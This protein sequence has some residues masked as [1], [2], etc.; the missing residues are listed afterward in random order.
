[1]EKLFLRAV[2]GLCIVCFAALSAAAV[3][4]QVVESPKPVGPKP[5]AP[6]PS[7]TPKPASKVVL[8][9]T[10]AE[11]IAEMVVFY[12]AFPGGR[13]TLNQIRKTTQEHGRSTVTDAS[14]RVDQAVYQR[15]VIRG[16][17]LFKE[18]IRLDQE[19]PTAKF[20]LVYNDENIFGIYNNSRF[21]P[22][23][24]ALKRFENQIFHGLEALLSYK[25][26]ESKLELQPREKLMGV[27]YYVVDVTDKQQRMTRF[28]ISAK[29]YRVMML[30]YEDEGV[31]YK[32]KFYDY[33]YAQGTLVPYRSVLWADDK[34]VEESEVLTVTFGQKVDE[35]MFKAGQG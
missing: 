19:L 20:A 26:N 22:R 25:E 2:I 33:N 21:T 3:F 35:E 29:T 1:M 34:I 15:Y 16:D 14:G 23:E 18:K 4:A 31:K 10:T 17:S 8:K 13:A 32:R 28:Y 11:D 7:P 30:R 5:A 12:Y 27:D 6:K 24:D 9:P